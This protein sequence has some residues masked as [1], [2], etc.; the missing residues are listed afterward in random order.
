MSLYVN[1]NTVPSNLG[2]YPN[3]LFNPKAE[4]AV[5]TVPS[6]PT[7]PVIPSIP[8]NLVNLPKE[9]RKELHKGDHKEGSVEEVTDA[10]REKWI[11]EI[12]LYSGM[13]ANPRRS[14][15]IFH[16]LG[17]PWALLSP[18]LKKHFVPERTND[19]MN[20]MLV[21]ELAKKQK[22]NLMSITG[23]FFERSSGNLI[24]EETK[25]WSADKVSEIIEQLKKDQPLLIERLAEIIMDQEDRLERIEKHLKIYRGGSVSV[26]VM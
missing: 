9:D 1:V 24:L 11:Q 13:R 22:E 10:L 3:S 16:L 21:L 5:N 18:G 26:S 2:L 17:A 14:R 12:R 7:N 23:R 4:D 19:P 25:D 6:I 15:R 20:A 8:I